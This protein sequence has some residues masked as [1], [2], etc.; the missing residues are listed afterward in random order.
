[1]T[2]HWYSFA[3]GPCTNNPDEIWVIDPSNADDVPAEERTEFADETII[4]WSGNGYSKQSA[5][6]S[7]EDEYIIDLEDSR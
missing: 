5:W 3:A 7:C 4:A 2:M 1:M 6:I